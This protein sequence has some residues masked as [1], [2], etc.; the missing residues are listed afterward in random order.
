MIHVR[1]FRSLVTAE[2]F[3]LCIIIVI[4]AISCPGAFTFYAEMIIGTFNEVA[5]SCLG[6]VNALGNSNGSGYTCTFHLADG[7]LFVGGDVT[8]YIGRFL[9]KHLTG[10]CYQ[11]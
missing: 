4:H 2:A 6:F 3:A 1:I 5:L 11:E 8:E 10:A 9:G 7:E